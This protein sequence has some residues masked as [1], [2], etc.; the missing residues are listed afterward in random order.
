MNNYAEW[1][2]GTDPTN[3]GSRCQ[4]SGFG[5]QGGIVSDTNLVLSWTGV[6]GKF[7]TIQKGTNVVDGFPLALETGIPGA[8]GVNSRTVIVDQATGFYR[9]KVE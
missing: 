4:I 7:Y 6:A 9:L 8:G 3:A 1:R 5:C 2:A